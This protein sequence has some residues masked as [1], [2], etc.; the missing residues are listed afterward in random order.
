M[1][2]HFV[3]FL[4]IT[5]K[6]ISQY[7]DYTLTIHQ[8]PM[9]WQLSDS[10]TIQLWKYYLCYPCAS[11]STSNTCHLIESD[12]TIHSS[13]QTP[14]SSKFNISLGI[15]SLKQTKPIF[16]G[17]LSPEKNMYWTWHNG[18]IQ[19]KAEGYK[20][21]PSGEKE[22]FVLH[23]GG[24]KIH[25]TDVCLEV[26]TSQ[27]TKH[28]RWNENELS[29]ILML[30]RKSNIMSESKEAKMLMYEIANCIILE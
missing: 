22:N 29:R 5:S 28:L 21:L 9:P 23:L 11:E 27:K 6:L 10:L 3:A 20:I 2:A 30:N 14:N 18:Y 7:D 17:D 13:R 15:D 1:K 8:P 19:L 4:I 25:R 12:T 26:S 16:L 24:Y